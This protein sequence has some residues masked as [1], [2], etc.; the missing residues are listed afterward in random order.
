MKEISLCLLVPVALL[1]LFGVCILNQ[2]YASI[3]PYVQT[4]NLSKSEI[5]YLSEKYGLDLSNCESIAVEY[6]SG[7]MPSQDPSIDTYCKIPKTLSKQYSSESDYTK[8]IYWNVEER[9]NYILIRIRD[10]NF[11][12]DKLNAIKNRGKRSSTSCF[13]RMGFTY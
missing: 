11:N 1:L 7:A 4:W 13:T 3:Y 9:N 12:D 6:E 8:K 10:E 2:S 5:T